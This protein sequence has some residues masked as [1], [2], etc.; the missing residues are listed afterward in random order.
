MNQN[1]DFPVF[2]QPTAGNTVF[3]IDGLFLDPS[4][5]NVFTLIINDFDGNNN[6]LTQIFNVNVD[7]D[8]GNNT[9]SLP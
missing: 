9:I 6:T 7:V 1:G 4:K 8:S 3:E 5:G 2:Y